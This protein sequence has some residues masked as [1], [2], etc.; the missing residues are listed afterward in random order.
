M[1]VWYTDMWRAF[2]PQRLKDYLGYQLLS[3]KRNLVLSPDYRDI[4]F[5]SCFGDEYL[6]YECLRVFYTPENV[7]PDFR[8]CDYAFSFDYPVTETKLSFSV[9]SAN[10]SLL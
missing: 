7:R 3:D 10:H 6:K 1:K 2:A 9:L 5:Y 4:L 8:K